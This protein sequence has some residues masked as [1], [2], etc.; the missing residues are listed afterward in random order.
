MN[1]RKIAWRLFCVLLTVA[2][3]VFSYFYISRLLNQV[4]LG[5]STFNWFFVALSIL[6]F[7]ASCVFMS[8]NWWQSSKILNKN[9]SNDQPLSF[10]A[11]LPYKY[12]P[13]SIFTFS[14]RAYFGVKL[15]LTFRQATFAQIFENA[16]LM[17]AN[18]SLFVILCAFAT[19]VLIGMST[20]IIFAFCIRWF[21]LIHP[22]AR[23]SF[24]SKKMVVD[25]KRFFVMYLFSLAGWF[26]CG[27]SFVVL[28]LAIDEPISLLSIL[29]AN[30]IAFSAG[31]I[32]FFAPGGIGV[33]EAIY[34]FFGIASVAILHWRLMIFIVDIV[35]GFIAWLLI[36]QTL[37]KRK[38]E[39]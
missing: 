31:M 23:L 22:K 5:A 13:T 18:F 27:L 9:V 29:I 8:L 4:D 15:G 35:L 24:R 7:V 36:R 6:L 37:N 33:R 39:G 2:L 11:S 12:L 34:G 16:S 21:V 3:L 10:L 28:H 38:L 30:T 25:T 14:S 19:H 26:L 20:L 1:A 32:A 17:A